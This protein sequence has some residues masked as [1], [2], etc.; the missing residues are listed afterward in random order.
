MAEKTVDRRV[1]KTRRL[2]RQG[3]TQLMKEKRVQDITVRELS[4]LC[5]INRGTFYLHYRDVFDMV[6]QVEQEVFEELCRV[7]DK[8]PCQEG[9][10]SA[11]PMLSHFFTYLQD[12]VDMGQVLTGPNGDLAFVNRL[13]GLIQ[14]KIRQVWPL[15]CPDASGEAVNYVSAYIT[16][17]C[18]GLVEAWLAG[19]AQEPPGKMAALCEQLILASMRPPT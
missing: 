12:N 19:G 18:V 3:L 10:D 11:R 8:A 9:K 6:E 16:S 7:L 5:D 17:G 2:L 1:R 14:D 15:I 13:K 4:E